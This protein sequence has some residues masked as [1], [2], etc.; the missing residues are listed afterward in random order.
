MFK[1]ILMPIDGSELAME[2]VGKTIAFARLIGAKLTAVHVAPEYRMAQ[3]DGYLISLQ[4]DFKKKFEARARE[5]GDALLRSVARQAEEA[6]VRCNVHSVN[7][8]RPHEEI[9]NIAKEEECDLI[10]MS[11]HNLGAVASEMLG[12]ETRKVVA[13][14]PAAVL[15]MS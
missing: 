7:N 9:I 10:M 12:G 4:P 13:N 8:D 11:S 2:S 14:A 1:H 3:D 6:G 5:E 15:V